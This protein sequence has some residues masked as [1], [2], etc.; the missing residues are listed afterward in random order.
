MIF[1]QD[2]MFLDKATSI[3]TSNVLANG[4]G[5]DA[6][7]PLFLVVH[8]DAKETSSLTFAVKTADTEDMANAVT[9]GTFTSPEN[10]EGYII[11]AKLPYGLK[12]FVRID[13]SGSP[14]GKISAGLAIDV[15]INK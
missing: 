6:G 11:A 5:G 2:A 1:D 3:A 4:G 15:P 12:K 9:L 8:S 13:G 10:A 7:D 14:A